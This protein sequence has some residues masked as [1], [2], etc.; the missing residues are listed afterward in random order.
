MAVVDEEIEQRPVRVFVVKVSSGETAHFRREVQEF[1]LMC[2]E[3][4]RA[5]PIAL[6]PCSFSPSSNPE[7]SE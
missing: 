3:G 1:G 7:V 4:S 6:L 5:D 2:L